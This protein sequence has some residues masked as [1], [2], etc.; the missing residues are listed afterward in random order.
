MASLALSIQA[1]HSYAILEAEAVR[2]S[3]ERGDAFLLLLPLRGEG[4]LLVL[5][6]EVKGMV[7]LCWCRGCACEL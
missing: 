1:E 4:L 7:P 3:Q 2:T 5:L 6:G